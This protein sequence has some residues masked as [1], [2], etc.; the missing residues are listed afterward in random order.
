V[1]AKVTPVTRH[2]SKKSRFTHMQLSG[3]MMMI[4]II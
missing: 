4:I 1:K 2:P 3:V